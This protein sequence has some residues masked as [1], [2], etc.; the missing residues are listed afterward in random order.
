MPVLVAPTRNP[1]P[2]RVSDPLWWLVCQILANWPGTLNGGTFAGKT[3]SHDCRDCQSASNYS[4]RDPLNKQGPGTT[5]AAFDLTFPSAQAGNYDLIVQFGTIVAEA[6]ANGDPRAAALFEVLVE[7]DFD[8]DPEG[9]V[10]YPTKKRRTPDR[11]HKWHAHLGFIR[12]F[13]G[14][15]ARS[16]KAIRDVASLL[17]REALAV[18]QAGRSI[19]ADP[20]TRKDNDDMQPVL[21]QITGDPTIRLVSMGQGH[22]PIGSPDELKRW[23]KFMSDNNMNTTVWQWDTGQIPLLGPDLRYVG[24][25]GALQ[26][27][28]A[29]NN[30]AEQ[31][32]DSANAAA[33]TA[34]AQTI[35]R[36]SAAGGGSIE[37]GALVEAVTDAVREAAASHTAATTAIYDELMAARAEITVLRNAALSSA[38]QQAA[39]LGGQNR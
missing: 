20:A 27:Q 36:L 19:F 18:W 34:L 37:T 15:D 4:T 33:L 35:E 29:A 11:T 14:N 30:A 22:I 24:N 1:N 17:C 7:A 16:W 28:V 26:G 9:F 8:Y 21:I 38:E 39:I 25:I 3:G 10:W 5:A 32:R 31:A 12:A 6:Y 23:Q 2:A 13:M